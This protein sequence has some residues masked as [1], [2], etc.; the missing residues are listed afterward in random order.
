MSLDFMISD[1]GAIGDGKTLN[2]QAIQTAIDA[3]SNSGGGRVI[4]PP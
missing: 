3:C 2:T 4:I 1:Y